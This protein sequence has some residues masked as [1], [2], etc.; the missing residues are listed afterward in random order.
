MYHIGF[1]GDEKYMKF[2]A[3]AMY[4]IVKNTDKS[5][6]Y[7]NLL[8]HE[9]V[10]N[11]DQANEKYC[12]HIIADSISEETRTKLFSLEKELNT[13]YP[14]SLEIHYTDSSLFDGFPLWRGNF[15][16]YY[17]LL[18]ADFLPDTVKYFLYLDGDTLAV[19][20]IREIF[21]EDLGEYA[22]GAVAG[23][24]ATI[25]RLQKDIVPAL[26]SGKKPYSF[27]SHN[28][29]FCSG[30]ML[31]NLEKWKAGNPLKDIRYFLNTYRVKYPDQDALNY[32]FKNAFKVLDFKYDMYFESKAAYHAEKAAAQLRQA[33]IAVQPL[34]DICILHYMVK[35]WDTAGLHFSCSEIVFAEYVP[36]W[37]EYAK[38]VPVFAQELEEILQSENFLQKAEK[39]RRREKRYKMLAPWYFVRRHCA[40]RIGQFLF[41]LNGFK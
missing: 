18:Y 4:S 13:L 23:Y 41:W 24:R 19:S 6:S 31:I 38:N 32:A 30:V 25:E 34:T 14:C 16:A 1:C 37:W 10:E 22:L 15:A 27:F 12:F 7:K 21:C 3:V 39:S 11:Q 35:P 9:I 40:R 5:K 36:L 8:P 33:G 26:D 17:R 2:I 28:C 20:D 29:Y